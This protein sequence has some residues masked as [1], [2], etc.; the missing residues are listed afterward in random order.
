MT[1]KNDIEDGEDIDI[2]L[3]ATGID[4]WDHD[5][6]ARKIQFEDVGGAAVEL[7]VFHNNDVADFEWQ[8]GEWYLLENAVGNEFR[9][10]M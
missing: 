10:E 1:V 8:V 6:V 4:E 9:G 5:T 3:R 7:T 2:T